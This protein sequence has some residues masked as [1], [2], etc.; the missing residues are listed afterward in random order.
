MLYSAEEKQIREM[1]DKA[2]ANHTIQIKLDQDGY[3]SWLCRKPGASM[4]WF[5]ITVIPGSMFLTG[6]LQSLTLC[7]EPDM[8]AWAKKAVDDIQYFAGKVT[9]ASGEKKEFDRDAFKAWLLKQADEDVDED[10][11]CMVGLCERLAEEVDEH[12]KDWLMEESR[13]IWI[14][15]P[16]RCEKWNPQLLWQRDAIRWFVMNLK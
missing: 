3:K 11:N 7:R 2:F 1:S 9:A 5:Q 15:E 6:D 4:Y 16:P 14:D 13:D 8:I 10:E 12:S